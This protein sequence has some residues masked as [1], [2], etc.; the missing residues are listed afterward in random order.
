MEKKSKEMLKNLPLLARISKDH[1]DLAGKSAETFTLSFS[2]PVWEKECFLVADIYS[3]SNPVHPQ[4]HVGWWAYPLTKKE[5]VKVKIS[6]AGD[7]FKVLFQ[8]RGA[9]E[10]WVNPEF[11]LWGHGNFALH[12]VIR[13]AE[14]NAIEFDDPVFLYTNKDLLKSSL[15]RKKAIERDMR[16]VVDTL[17]NWCCWPRDSS[18]HIVSNDIREGDAI[19]NFAF[20]LYKLFKLNNIKCRLY[21][22]NFDMALRG[23][24][25]HISELY[26]EAKETDLIFFNFSIFC[27]HLESI[28]ALP[29]KK[30]FFYHNITPPKMF[31]VYDAELASFCAKAYEQFDLAKNFDVFIANSEMTKRDLIKGLEDRERAIRS[32]DQSPA[33]SKPPEINPE[34]PVEKRKDTRIFVCPPLLNAKKWEFLKGEEFRLPQ[35]GTKLLY[36]GRIAPHKKI[37]DLL[38]LFREYHKLAPDSSLLIAG[39]STFPGYM[40]YLSHILNHKTREIKKNTYFL[41]SL[42]ERGLKTVYERSSLFITM[43]EHE[44]FCVPLVE[45]MY[46]QKPVFAFAQEAVRETMGLSGRLFYRKDFETIAREIKRVLGNEDERARIIASQDARFREISEKANGRIIWEAIEKALFGNEGSV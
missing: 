12:I 6:R 10:K 19:G 29:G 35:T 24:I 17:R 5:E 11:K 45:A 36:V 34:T 28:A 25:R 27:P 8:K 7:N 41:E 44:G 33:K 30:I 15:E 23:T 42:S 20:D 32:V 31:Q 26:Y 1:L 9:R 40:N 38:F 4:G 21:A 46:F 18:V 16:D 3:A 39:K 2:P 37:E 14:N 13:N 43:S 22:Y